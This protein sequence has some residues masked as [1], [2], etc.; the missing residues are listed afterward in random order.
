MSFRTKSFYGE[1]ITDYKVAATQIFQDK[2]TKEAIELTKEQVNIEKERSAIG[3]E[4]K[5]SSQTCK[6]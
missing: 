1:H 3:T 4:I 6:N 2:Y 5:Y